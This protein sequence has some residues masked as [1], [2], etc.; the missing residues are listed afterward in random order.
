M[1]KMIYL[2]K[3]LYFYGNIFLIFRILFL[4]IKFT[5]TKNV[6]KIT[7]VKSK[8]RKKYEYEMLKKYVEFVTRIGK[9]IGLKRTCLSN[10][11]ILFRLAKENGYN[12]KLNFGCKALQD[13]KQNKLNVLGH[14][15]ITEEN[16]KDSDDSQNQ[17]QIIFQIP[18]NTRNI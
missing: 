2:I 5:F 16:N 17:Y 8:K 12:V 9:K 7:I 11:L 4:Q 6:L 1:S 13:A 3:K 14:S 18:E 15:W 10:S